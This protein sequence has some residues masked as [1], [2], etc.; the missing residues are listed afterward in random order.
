MNSAGKTGVL[1]LFLLIAG[2]VLG[3]CVEEKTETDLTAR[4]A[5][6]SLCGIPTIDSGI[7]R[8]IISAG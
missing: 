7:R 5:L 2:G 1:L 4:S 3:G 8:F 6:L